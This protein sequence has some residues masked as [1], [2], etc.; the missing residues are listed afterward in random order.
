MIKLFAL[1]RLHDIEEAFLNESNPYLVYLMSAVVLLVVLFAIR[2]SLHR[3]IKYRLNY[4][5]VKLN[6]NEIKLDEVLLQLIVILNLAVFR[7]AF[8]PVLSKV[9]NELN[10]R[11]QA[12]DFNQI[13][14][15]SLSLNPLS[16]NKVQNK[17]KK[18]ELN[19]ETYHILVNEIKQARFAAEKL[20]KLKCEQLVGAVT[21]LHQ[22]I[23]KC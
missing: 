5:S 22:E 7:S 2:F 10:A 12:Q 19:A 14:L 20:T 18:A 8:R 3:K 16:L 23:R 11:Q 1:T 13:N 17:Q 4:L 9:G 21:L 15:N 6:K